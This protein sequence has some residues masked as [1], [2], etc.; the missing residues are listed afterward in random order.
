[1]F[2]ALKPGGEDI[3]DMIVYECAVLYWAILAFCLS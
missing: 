2:P 3:I 1:M